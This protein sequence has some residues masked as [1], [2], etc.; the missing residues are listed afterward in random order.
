[1]KKS[2]ELTCT[3]NGLSS[4]RVTGVVNSSKW[5]SSGVISASAPMD[6]TASI[7]PWARRHRQRVSRRLAIKAA[8]SIMAVSSKATNLPPNAARIGARN[9]ARLW[10]RAA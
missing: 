2:P 4:A 6:L 8:R 9:A 5:I 3:S 7:I 1:M 10:V